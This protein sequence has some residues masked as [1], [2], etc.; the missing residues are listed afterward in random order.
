MAILQGGVPPQTNIYISQINEITSSINAVN[1]GDAS[2][3][4]TA[5]LKQVKGIGAYNALNWHDELTTKVYDLGL[6]I[7]NNCS[8][9]L[10]IVKTEISNSTESEKEILY[11]IESEIVFA[12]WN[13]ADERT[14]SY[15]SELSKRYPANAEFIHDLGIIE[16]SKNKYIE[17]V[18]Y[19][20]A[21]L[22]LAPSNK[23]YL[24]DCVNAEV[25][26][27]ENLIIQEKF[28]EAKSY[29]NNLLNIRKTYANDYVYNNWF[30]AIQS[31]IKD[32][33]LIRSTLAKKEADIE[34]RLDG[35]FEKEKFKAIEMI[36][37]FTAIIAFIFSTISIATKYSFKEAL[38]LEMGFG[39]ILILFALTISLILSSKGT[40]LFKDI[41]LYSFMI[42][43]G[44]LVYMYWS[45]K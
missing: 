33:V 31:R 42:I 41:R 23:V 22:K 37:I 15:V 13:T 16:L 5:F 40:Q 25:E 10:D 27:L 30:L 32:H 28:D 14:F 6:L 26:H 34:T 8:N 9:L 35:K 43:A 24:K 45:T 4:F 11:F 2:T 36:G 18:N 29:L 3:K 1:I 20:L 21:A 19:F 12:I 17:A 7:A 38:Q 44:A 39:L